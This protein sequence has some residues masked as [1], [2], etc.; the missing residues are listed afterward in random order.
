MKPLLSETRRF[1]VLY[2]LSMVLSGILAATPVAAGYIEK[3]DING[4]TIE[5]Y[6]PDIPAPR[7]SGDGKS[8]FVL[9]PIIIVKDPNPP[10]RK[11]RIPPPIE[12]QE[13]GATFTI[14]YTAAGAQDPLGEVCQTFPEEAKAAFNAAASIWGSLLNSTV[15]ITITACWA[16][17]GATDTLGY[18]GSPFSYRDFTNAP[19]PN[20]WYRGALAN[21][22]AGS[23]L[24]PNSPDMFIT[25]NSSI[26]W[27]Y[28]T[29][30]NTPPD[31][32]DLMSVVLHEIA[33]GLDFSGSMQYASG[34]GS[35]GSGS[36]YPSIYDTF[37]FDGAG[38]QLID[39]DVYP[40]PS[41]ALG[42][43]L[44][45]NDLYFQ[46]NN[47]MS[48]NGGQ[49]V[50]I[51]APS[52][53]MSGSSYA[54][55][56]YD[57]F[58]GGPNTLMVYGIG[59]GVSIHDPGPVTMGL[60]KDLGWSTS[61][62]TTYYALPD[63]GQTTCYDND[64]NGITCPA[65]GEPFYGQDAHYAGAQLAYLDNGD[66]TVTDLNTGLTWQQDGGNYGTWQEARNI[67]EQLN[68]SALGGYTDWRLPDRRELVSIVDYGRYNPAIN[69][70][71]FLSPESQAGYYWSSTPF[72]NIFLTKPHV[73]SVIFSGGAVAYV[74]S[75]DLQ[76]LL[77]VRCVRGNPLPLGEFTDNGNGTVTDTVTGLVWQQWGFTRGTWQDALAYCESLTLAGQD[78]WRLPNIREL[79]S[80]VDFTRYYLAIDPVLPCGWLPSYWSSSTWEE[81]PATAWNVDFF[82]GLVNPYPKNSPSVYIRCVRAEREQVALGEALDA[83]EL[84]W[85]TF[86]DAPW[87]GQTQHSFADGDAAQTTSMNDLESSHVETAVTGPGVLSFYWRVSSEANFDYLR[88]F[89][90]DQ[91]QFAISGV[92]DWEAR[93]VALPEGE[94]VLR[95]TYEKGSSVSEND[96]A[97]WVDAVTFNV[98]VGLA[99]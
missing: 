64:G 53:W 12:Y 81:Y 84:V 34:Q 21:S 54:H 38:Y 42:S 29:D 5:V 8:L 66:G 46:G 22:L 4:V 25:Y 23:D 56:D 74:E 30:G 51:Y 28:G 57:T 37:I 73:W 91:E 3:R 83:P 45:S 72:I 2:L 10:Y 80:L 82:A 88:F 43:A 97:A 67:C 70:D 1:Q 79:E 40:N 33:H 36:E 7:L 96:D 92:I 89:V 18:S 90:N 85:T 58:A 15:P 63:T 39:T 48:A 6:V 19:R 20:T 16:D 9:N 75:S 76:N 49:K 93:T 11:L 86:G 95:W 59:A 87:V 14:V 47:A 27:Y 41:T 94:H 26:P 65:P 44:T 69:T 55:L 31:R 78:D 35:W 52:T 62:S 17:L 50:R 99:P 61:G 77:Y 13:T 98:A 24:D 32:I 71:F 60:L 68:I